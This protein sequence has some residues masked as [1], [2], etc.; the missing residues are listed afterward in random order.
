MEL[1]QAILESYA[2][3]TPD[4]KAWSL[5][6]FETT[7]EREKDLKKIF[8]LIESL[9]NHVHVAREIKTDSIV[10]L[11][12]DGS[13]E[14]SFFPIITTEFSELLIRHQDLP[15]RK[16][17]VLPG[18]RANLA[19]FKLRRDPHLQSLKTESWSIVKYRQLRNL[20]DNPLLTRELFASQIT[21]DPPEYSSTQLALF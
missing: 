11:G 8:G 20:S 17:I 4:L 21:G 18:S 5:R 2:D 14:F 16:L 1:V 7:R 19:A 13:P 3:P 10:W 12:Q 15:G 9:A 6:T